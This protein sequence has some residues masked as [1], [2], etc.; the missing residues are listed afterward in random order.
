[1]ADKS[2]VCYY[3]TYLPPFSDTR[4]AP[5]D[6]NPKRIRVVAVRSSPDGTDWGE[7]QIVMVQD[8]RDPGDTQFME[9]CPISVKGGF[10]GMVTVYHPIL[11]TID[12]QMAASR[13]GVN[14][15]TVDRRPALPNSPLG[16]YGGGMIWQMKDPI[17][18][19]NRLH[20]YYSG[21][22]GIHGEIFDTRYGPRLKAR[23]ETV[24]GEKTPTIPFAGA[25]C[26]ASWEYDRMYALFPSAGG[27]TTGMAITKKQVCAG[28]SLWLNCFA[29]PGGSLQAE[30]LDIEGLPIPGFSRDDCTAVEG[31]QRNRKLKWKAG[32]KAPQNAVKVKFY[33]TRSF[34][35]GFEWRE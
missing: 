1:L 8:W 22:E 14:W 32:N 5:Y 21:T 6:N 20:V 34:L 25:L 15:W 28:K 23:G 31:D 30:L 35:Y 13:D 4:L 2:Y 27:P 9:I 33:L 12:L 29:K 24:I 7:E 10:I 3:K 11:Q 18:E 19:G 17:V 16:D 26:R